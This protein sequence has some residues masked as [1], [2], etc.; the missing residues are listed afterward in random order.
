M[1]YSEFEER[2]AGSFTRGE[3]EFLWRNEHFQTAIKTFD[4]G[5]LEGLQHV[6]RIGVAL[7]LQNSNPR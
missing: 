6:E 5:T 1:T 3:R 2:F 7:V 4:T